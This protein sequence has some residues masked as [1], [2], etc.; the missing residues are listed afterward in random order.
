MP[1]AQL[2]RLL[3]SKYWVQARKE[4][5]RLLATE[6]SAE[7][8]ARVY[9]A[10]GLAALKC[11]EY[12]AAIEMSHRAIDLCQETGDIET[13]TRA[14]FVAGT[15]FLFLKDYWPTESHLLQFIDTA[16]S[17]PALEALLPHGH[18]NLGVLAEYRENYRDAIAGYELA[19][20]AWLKSGNTAEVVRCYR[21]LAW[22]YLLLN[23]PDEALPYLSR[24]EMQLR[25]REDA[26]C[27]F[28]L[29]VDKAFYHYLGG[30]VSESIRLCEEIFA[31][32]GA[33]GLT[34]EHLAL[35]AWITGE[36][37]LSVGRDKEAII[38]ADLAQTYA[39]NANWP[40][41]VT[42]ADDLRKRA[43]AAEER[44]SMDD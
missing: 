9:R 11:G 15:S 7:D 41:M 12:F 28:W 40:F 21:A 32:L 8:R 27:R 23:Q 31:H 26:E 10:G 24:I 6:L 29:L 39:V 4:A 35:T 13:A 44:Q 38:F 42:R 37:S 17:L 30:T 36:N 5:D 18:F 20:S 25:L 1:L 34:D 2:D 3:T 33:P 19:L 22:C 43:V 16:S 14:H